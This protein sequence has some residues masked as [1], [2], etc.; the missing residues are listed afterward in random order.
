MMWWR[1]HQKGH[2]RWSLLPTC[3]WWNIPGSQHPAAEAGVGVDLGRGGGAEGAVGCGAGRALGDFIRTGASPSEG[4]LEGA[5]LQAASDSARSGVP[6]A[7]LW[8]T[9]QRLQG[10][11]KQDRRQLWRRFQSEMMGADLRRLRSAGNR[12]GFR[13]SSSRTHGCISCGM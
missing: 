4:P 13:S 12:D 10:C 9:K 1:G 2:P 8:R 3:C 6:P 7:V 5:A 11:G